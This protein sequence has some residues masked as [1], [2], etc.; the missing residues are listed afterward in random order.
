MRYLFRNVKLLNPAQEELRGGHKSH[1][2][3]GA[4]LPLNSQSIAEESTS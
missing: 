4:P 1:P 3:R 2:G